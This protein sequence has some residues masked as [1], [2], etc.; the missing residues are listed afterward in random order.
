MYSEKSEYRSQVYSEFD[1]FEVVSNN[2][3]DVLVNYRI[4]TLIV[5]YWPYAI[6]YEADE[7]WMCSKGVEY[8]VELSLIHTV[9]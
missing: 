3:I 2:V 9:P 4:H 8:R 7:R 5:V 1:V 6:K